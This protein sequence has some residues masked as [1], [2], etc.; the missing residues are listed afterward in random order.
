M[1]RIAN[2]SF[3]ARLLFSLGLLVVL[4][5]ALGATRAQGNHAPVHFTGI[6]NDFTPSTVKGGPWVMGGK[7][8]LD[9][10]GNFADFNAA[11]TMESSDAGIPNVVDPTNTATRSA[12]THHIVVDHASLSNDTSH[13]SSYNPATTGPVIVVTGP[14]QIITGNGGPAPFQA[15]GDS[16]LWICI[17][18]GTQVP[19]SNLSLQFVGPATGHFGTQYIHGVVLSQKGNNEH[20]LG[21][22]M[23]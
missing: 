13:C 10:H 3:T 20:N 22:A 11:L 21:P 15:M 19:Y 9:I 1:S 4:A 23:Q 8:T 18:G 7:W 5:L 17:A 6:L 14:A 2:R 16:T 12:H